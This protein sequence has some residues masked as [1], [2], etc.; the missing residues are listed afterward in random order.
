[1]GELIEAFEAIDRRWLV[2]VQWHPERTEE[3]SAGAADL[4]D[5]FVTEAATARVATPAR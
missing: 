4:I 3:V 1:V 2:G 5:A